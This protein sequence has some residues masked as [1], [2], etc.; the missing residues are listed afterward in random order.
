MKWNDR[1]EEVGG[2]GVVC[3]YVSVVSWLNAM[4]GKSLGLSVLCN[5]LNWP[6]PLIPFKEKPSYHLT[7]R[8]C[9]EH[10][11][12][13]ILGKASKEPPQ[14]KT[15]PLSPLSMSFWHGDHFG[16]SMWII[17][18]TPPI[19]LYLHPHSLTFSYV[20][21]Y[22][23]NCSF[24]YVCTDCPRCAKIL[25]LLS[26]KNL[27]LVYSKI[28]CEGGITLWYSNLIIAFLFSLF[29]MSFCWSWHSIYYEYFNIF[30]YSSSLNWYE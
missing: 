21:S 2:R 25:Q 1:G 16:I 9:R 27:S 30:A 5:A 19:H 10:A 20:T 11:N 8:H 4:L 26:E 29:C 23:I 3:K 6:K 7:P 22:F 13:Q 18:I 15:N 14:K 24:Y 12:H 28:S 17:E